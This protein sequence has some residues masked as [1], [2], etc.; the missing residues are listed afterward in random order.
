ML[1]SNSVFSPDILGNILLVGMEGKST[2]TLAWI[3]LF[4]KPKAVETLDLRIQL[5]SKNA[6]GLAHCSS[7]TRAYSMEVLIDVSIVGGPWVILIWRTTS[8]VC[9][10]SLLVSDFG[11]NL[12][13]GPVDRRLLHRVNCSVS[14]PE[15]RSIMGF[16]NRVEKEI[17]NPFVGLGV[18]GCR[19]CVSDRSAESAGEDSSREVMLKGT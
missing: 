18:L 2:L 3:Y 10:H 4:V 6:D 5:V 11:R 1:A 8:D 7:C 16:G 19:G 14:R 9:A 13:R 12:I 15:T 17:A